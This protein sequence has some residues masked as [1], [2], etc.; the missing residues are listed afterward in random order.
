MDSS[1]EMIFLPIGKCAS[2]RFS[3][4]IECPNSHEMKKPR[5]KIKFIVHF[6]KAIKTKT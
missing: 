5:I 4:V 2:I 6:P 1:V 3:R